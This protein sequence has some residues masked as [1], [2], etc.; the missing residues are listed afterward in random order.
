MPIY[1]FRNTETDELYDLSLRLNERETYLQENPHVKQ[2]LSGA[3]SLHSGA[4]LTG[5]KPDNAFRDKLK[6]IKK[7]HS[8]G[9]SERSKAKINTF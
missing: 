8:Q 3:P 5:R 9:Y 6:E 7:A 4:G 1:T 2:V